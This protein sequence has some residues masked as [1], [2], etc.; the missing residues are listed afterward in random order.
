LKAQK[1]GSEELL[2][3]RAGAVRLLR[4]FPAQS[5]ASHFNF[6]RNYEKKVLSLFPIGL[7]VLG[8]A[9][10]V[11]SLASQVG[12]QTAVQAATEE[13]ITLDVRPTV[14]RSTTVREFR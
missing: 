14:E 9:G 8:L 5:L 1:G 11:P 3:V 2:L 12:V 7:V 4:H 10:I 6:R 13:T